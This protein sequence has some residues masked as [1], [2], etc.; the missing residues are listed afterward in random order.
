ML[1]GFIP[2]ALRHIFLE[3]TVIMLLSIFNE[4]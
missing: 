1:Q 4:Q 3:D 2:R